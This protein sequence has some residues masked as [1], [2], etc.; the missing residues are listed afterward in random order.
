M[1]F[2]SVFKKDWLCVGHVSQVAKIGDY[3]TL[4][5]FGEPLVVV[6]GPD[7]IRV[8]SRV[9]LHRWAPVA[10]G[11]GNVKLFSCPF[12]RWAYGL[13]GQL[14]TAGNLRPFTYSGIGIFSPALF[15]GCTAGRFPLRPLLERAIAAG[16]LQGERHDG[17]WHDI[18]TPERLAALNRELAQKGR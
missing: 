8:L 12:H 9:C 13:D 15:A 17:L 1:L 5:L 3:F 4:E 11:A 2:R 10:E 14:V 6:R 16:R 18:G 7:R